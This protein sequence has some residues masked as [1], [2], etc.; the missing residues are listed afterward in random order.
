MKSFW[1]L[2]A[3]IRYEG[4]DKLPTG[5]PLIVVANHQSTWDVPVVVWAFRKHHPKFI[6]KIELGKG[7]PSISYNLRHGGSALIDR[8]NG[9]QS[10]KELIKL[11]QRIEKNN[12]CA[13]IYPEGTRSKDGKVKKFQ[14]G[15]VKTLMKASPSAVVVPFVIDGHHELHKMGFPLTLGLTI[16]YRVLDPIEREGFSP[17]EIVDMAETRI[18]AAL[19]QA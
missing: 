9:G 10:I 12:Y 7:I 14:S 16:R 17:E 4:F 1:I 19:G 3:R 5:R 8:K 11:G 13:C 2:G 6:S 18:K 15:G